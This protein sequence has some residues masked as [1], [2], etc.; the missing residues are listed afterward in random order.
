MLAAHLSVPKNP[1]EI[2][3]ARGRRIVPQGWEGCGA[4]LGGCVQALAA[5]ILIYLLATLRPLIV[6]QLLN[7]PLDIL[8]ASRGS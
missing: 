5:K 7:H 8:D 3:L 2:A 6:L 4:N 1:P